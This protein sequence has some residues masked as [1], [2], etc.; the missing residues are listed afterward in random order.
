LTTKEFGIGTRRAT[1]VRSNGGLVLGLRERAF[2][3]DD[4]FAL[5]V[6]VALLPGR[7][8]V[9]DVTVLVENGTILEVGEGG[10]IA[11][12]GELE[13]VST[14]SSTLLPGL[15]DSHVHLSFSGGLD[16]VGDVVGVSDS[17][18][19]L[20]AYHNSMVALARGVT[21][22]VDCGAR[23]GVVIKMRDM[24]E[25][26][27]LPG[28][29]VLA[30]G[31]P[32]TTTAGHC[33][34]LG[35]CADS[36]DEVVRE[37]RRQVGA[38][39]DLLKVMVT[40]GNLTPGSNP[41]MLQYAPEV[42]LALA[43][44]AR[45]LGRILVAHAHSE[46]AVALAAQAGIPIVSHAT[47]RSSGGIGLSDETLASLLGAGTVIDA[48]ITVGM[49]E[50]PDCTPPDGGARAQVRSEMLT[51]FKSMHN[52]G[53]RLLAGTDGGVTSVGHGG[54]AR[55]VLALHREVGLDLVDALG[56]ATLNPAAAVGIGATTGSISGGLSAD[57]ILLDGDIRTQPDLLRTPAAVWSR[58]R[59][60]A[61]AGSLAI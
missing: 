15:I 6:G 33:A 22:L 52:S 14:P 9:E 18:L 35:A 3:P 55:A 13:L 34:W 42:V 60:A 20:R 1:Q 26:G 31:A 48:T 10:E 38:G 7:G 56:A 61:T 28:P 54:V 36:L 27:E 4:T 47:C 8:F 11:P 21:T 16:P 19:A 53:V 41:S 39:A 50:D 44:E 30:A 43:A 23:G 5:R 49:L 12:K 32:I 25:S 37:A 46:E 51:V 59:L 17:Q 58:G 45:R 40:G 24:L 2:G 29:R 57:L